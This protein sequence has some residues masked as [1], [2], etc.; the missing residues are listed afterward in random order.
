MDEFKSNVI[1]LVNISK[2]VDQPVNIAV[3]KSSFRAG[4][5]GGKIG[6]S[7][8][9]NEAPKSKKFFARL[10][11]EEIGELLVEKD[12]ISTKNATRTA[13]RLYLH[14]HS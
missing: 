7:E 14:S 8:Y 6:G 13:V 10:T 5:S 12:S 3:S 1:Q 4:K 2:I 11:E 9:E